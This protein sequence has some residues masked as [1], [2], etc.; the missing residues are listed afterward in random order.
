MY[1][2]YEEYCK[3]NYIEKRAT[4]ATC[5]HIFVVEFNYSF[6]FAKKDLCDVCHIYADSSS[7]KKLQLEEEYA[8]HREDRSLAR[9]IKNVSKEEAK[10][11]NVHI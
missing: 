2:Q 5:D 10:V 1:S 11:K 6:F 3:E 7:E 4:E 9:I 8:K